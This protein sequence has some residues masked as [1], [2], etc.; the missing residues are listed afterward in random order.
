MSPIEAA[1]QEATRAELPQVA[2]EL[3]QALGQRLVAYATGVRSPQAVGRWAAGKSDPQQNTEQRLRT[4]YRVF[5]I[6][7]ESENDKTIRAW[8]QSANPQLA[9]QAPIEVLR[10]STANDAAAVAE[11]AV[12]FADA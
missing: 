2:Q 4:L 5:L 9:N 7:Q 8:F 6:L 11:A 12:D 3:Q 10:E 1:F